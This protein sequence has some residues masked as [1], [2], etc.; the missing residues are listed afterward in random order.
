MIDIW[1]N[2]VT[3]AGL[4]LAAWFSVT[5]LM[6][7]SERILELLSY[8]HGYYSRQ[9]DY[10]LQL[11]RRTLR[12]IYELERISTLNSQKTT[13]P[14]SRQD[15]RYIRRPRQSQPT[16]TDPA[17]SFRNSVPAQGCRVYTK[18]EG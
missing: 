17:I 15:A 8:L 14:S 11:Q 5:Q 10:T 1:M 6:K 18:R 3:A 4:A 13:R 16:T 9:A 12:A 2:I 7:L